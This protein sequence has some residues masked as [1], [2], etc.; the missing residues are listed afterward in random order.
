[1]K[2][3]DL[4]TVYTTHDAGEAEIIKGALHAKGLKAE[5]DG[6]RQ[7]GF[8]GTLEVEILVRA[9]DADRARKVIES[10]QKN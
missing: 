4:I 2:P 1:M 6:E 9:E 10:H 8:T 3:D 7:A 5:I